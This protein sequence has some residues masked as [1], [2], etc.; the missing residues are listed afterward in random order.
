MT[1]EKFKIYQLCLDNEAKRKVDYAAS[2]FDLFKIVIY[3]D[4]NF[5]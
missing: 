3:L 2:L 5:R 4:V 1:P